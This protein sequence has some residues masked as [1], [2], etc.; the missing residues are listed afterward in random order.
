MAREPARHAH[1]PPKS[2]EAPAADP[3]A[4][5]EPRAAETKT[6]EEA[7]AERPKVSLHLGKASA[8]SVYA[9]PYGSEPANIDPKTGRTIPPTPKPGDKPADAEDGE[10]GD[11]RRQ[12]A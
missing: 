3:P 7:R 9:T 12:R 10:N 8:P 5:T 2:R 6:T 11:D 1:E 4:K